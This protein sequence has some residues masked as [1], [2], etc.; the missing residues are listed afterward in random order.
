MKNVLLII[1]L[2]V[3]LF[4][5]AQDQLRVNYKKVYVSNNMGEVLSEKMEEG[6]IVFTEDLETKTVTVN[7][8]IKGEDG[9]YDH[10]SSFSYYHKPSYAKAPNGKTILMLNL[11]NE[12]GTISPMQYH[13]LDESILFLDSITG[14]HLVFT[15]LT[16]ND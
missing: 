5:S 8:F 13:L 3:G 1:C 6:K 4:C 15:M 10:F 16:I 11:L 7:R 9:I 12:S 14:K 2:F